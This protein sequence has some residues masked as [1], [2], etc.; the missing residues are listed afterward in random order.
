MYNVYITTNRE[1]PE[2]VFG[3]GE[4]WQVA[5]E[6]E[7]KALIESTLNLYQ[8]GQWCMN[9]PQYVWRDGRP[10]DP[11]AAYYIDADA[12]AR[13]NA[14]HEQ[15]LAELPEYGIYGKAGMERIHSDAAI[16]AGLVSSVAELEEDSDD[17]FKRFIEAGGDDSHSGGSWWGVRC[18]A[19]E[20]VRAKA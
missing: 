7:A 20:I 16:L 10:G 19:A 15:W 13:Q 4:P 17:L 18:E 9:G 14:E 12:E 8:R 11:V 5:T 1:N 3:G 6:K 2:Q